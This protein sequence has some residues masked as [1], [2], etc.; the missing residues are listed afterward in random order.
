MNNRIISPLLFALLFPFIQMD[1]CAQQCALFEISMS[2]RISMSDIIIEG[3]V[4]AKESYWN[5]IHTEIFTR[6]RIEIYKVFKG[7]ITGFIPNSTVRQGP[8]YIDLITQGGIVGDEM[9]RV[10]PSLQLE[11]GQLGVYF[12]TESVVKRGT[13][14]KYV[15][16]G[17]ASK[18]YLPTAGPQG[19]LAYNESET[20]ASDHF[21]FYPDLKL[22]VYTPIT[23][24]VGKNF[25]EVRSFNPYTWYSNKGSRGVLPSITSF[26]P[27]TITAGTFDT[28]TIIGTDFGVPIFDA[29]NTQ[30]NVGFYNSNLNNSY[31]FY[32]SAH[33]IS[34]TTDTIIMTVPMGAGT[35]KIK[36]R[37]NSGAEGA[38]STDSLIVNYNHTN[39]MSG[40]VIYE[41]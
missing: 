11:M 28:L 22:D 17:K 2:K 21:R 32:D 10:T 38:F 16:T 36:V 12:L 8:F 1:L 31:T 33:I 18:I 24:V 20:S 37:D 14:S 40:G 6:N 25:D 4:T 41:P 30:S 3:R 9:Y 23:A 26:S 35:G 34:W 29:G 27:D 13:D 39:L 7:T 19:H 15:E 5:S